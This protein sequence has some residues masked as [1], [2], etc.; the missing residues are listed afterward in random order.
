MINDGLSEALEAI[1]RG[2]LT[3]V[4]IKTREQVRLAAEG[5]AE[6]QCG[7]CGT[8]RADGGPPILHRAG[9][10]EPARLEP[11]W[12]TED[13]EPKPCTCDGEWW[14]GE[15]VTGCPLGPTALGER[16]EGR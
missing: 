7:S 4:Q 5:R 3:P 13:R 15:H 2:E 9:C 10:Q 11:L 14:G 6:G 12:T 16:L 1:H 8:Y